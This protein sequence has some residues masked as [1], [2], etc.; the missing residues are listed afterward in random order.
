LQGDFAVVEFLSSDASGT[1][2]VM[3]LDR[4]RPLTAANRSATLKPDSFKQ[5]TIDVPDDLRE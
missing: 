2:D 5:D 3:S 1:T 4:C